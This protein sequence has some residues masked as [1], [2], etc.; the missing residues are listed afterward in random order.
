M[1]GTALRTA[2]AEAFPTA[3]PPPNAGR[4]QP[5]EPRHTYCAC[6]SRQAGV[7]RQ[8]Y[9]RRLLAQRGNLTS[10]S[11]AFQPPALRA[12]WHLR[13]LKRRPLAPP[14]CGWRRRMGRGQSFSD[15]MATPTRALAVR[16]FQSLSG[17]R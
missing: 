5:G 2:R 8:R 7:T 9:A 3:A 12:V 10:A 15:K 1:E 17:R 14:L 16:G 11:F 6:A 4:L 13:A